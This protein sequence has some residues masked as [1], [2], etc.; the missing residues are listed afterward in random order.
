LTDRRKRAE[1]PAIFNTQTE[2]WQSLDRP[3]QATDKPVADL[4]R[5][6]LERMGLPAPTREQLERHHSKF[7]PAYPVQARK[8]H[9][10][11]I[12]AIGDLYGIRRESKSV[13]L[14]LFAEGLTE[15]EICLRLGVKPRTLRTLLRA[16]SE[17]LAVAV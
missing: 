3:G 2:T 14:E 15:A 17:A 12:D 16:Q 11:A 10:E 6:Y 7:T 1:T 9:E 5:R 13:A 4:D 8:A